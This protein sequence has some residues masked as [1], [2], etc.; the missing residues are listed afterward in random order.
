MQQNIWV[1]ISKSSACL[2][3][4]LLLEQFPQLWQVDD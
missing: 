1:A 2:S 4:S 3:L